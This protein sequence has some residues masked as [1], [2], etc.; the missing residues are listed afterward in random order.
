[1]NLFS[2][3]IMKQRVLPAKSIQMIL[4]LLSQKQVQV[5]PQNGGSHD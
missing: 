4:I 1:M 2:K 3:T 5:K